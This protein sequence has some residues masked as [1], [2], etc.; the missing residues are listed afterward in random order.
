MTNFSGVTE[1]IAREA[2]ELAL[3]S[4]ENL[5]HGGPGHLVVLRPGVAPSAD[6]ELPVVYR[7]SW[8]EK[9]DWRGPY[10]A[11]AESK[12]RIS[13]TTGLPS[14]TVQQL[15]P[16]LYQQ[17]WTKWGGSA[18]GEGGLVVAY[19]GDKWFHDQFYSELVVSAIKV[20]CLREIDAVLRDPGTL[21]LGDG[22]EK[23]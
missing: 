8:G 3:P 15:H 22:G 7:R 6:A 5:S 17:G 23:P 10:D 19:S 14:H 13:W 18:V 20:V 16:Y 4:I 11:I 21:F 12:A 2:V 9:K 1:A